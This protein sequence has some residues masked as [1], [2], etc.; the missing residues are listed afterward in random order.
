MFRRADR[1]VPCEQQFVLDLASESFAR[2]STGQG[3]TGGG[4]FLDPARVLFASTHGAS[5]ACPP[6]PAPPLRPLPLGMDLFV[7]R[8]DGS[9]VKRLV[10]SDGYDGQP[11]VAPDGV[12]IFAS[13]RDGDLEI[14]A[15]SADGKSPRRLTHAPGAD[16]GPSVSRDGRRIVFHRDVPDPAA[17]SRHTSLVSQGLVEPAR[18]EVWVMDRDGSR[19]R[20]VTKLGAI[21]ETPVFTPDGKRIVFASNHPQPKGRNFDLWVVNEDGSNLQRVTSSPAFDGTPAFSPDGASLVFASSRGAVTAGEANLF[22]A[23]WVE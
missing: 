5:S 10:K 20:Q 15:V 13:A 21:V 8:A 16:A 22:L 2:V 17:A 7:A 4:V 11:V 3:M 6:P 9:A 19:P 14:Y 23:R 12:V 1:G 18:S